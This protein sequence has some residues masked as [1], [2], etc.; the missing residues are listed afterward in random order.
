[1]ITIRELINRIRWD[2]EYGRGEFAIGIEQF[3]CNQSAVETVLI[4]RRDNKASKGVPDEKTSFSDNCLTHAVGMC[5][6]SGL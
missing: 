6:S 2:P 5:C 1:M 3:A 4:V